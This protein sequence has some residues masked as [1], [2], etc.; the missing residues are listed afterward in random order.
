MHVA[1]PSMYSKL[2][3]FSAENLNSP[4]CSTAHL[5]I[6][7]FLHSNKTA[8]FEMAGPAKMATASR[9]HIMSTVSVKG[10][11]DSCPQMDEGTSDS[12]DDDEEEN[13]NSSTDFA[14]NEFRESKVC[15]GRRG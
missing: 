1:N 6:G 7:H 12:W 15:W 9:G 3:K 8:E 14:L 2:S 13:V 4:S 11:G 10:K 5:E